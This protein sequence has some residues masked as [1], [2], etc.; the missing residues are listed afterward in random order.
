M[1]E[2]CSAKWAWLL[3]FFQSVIDV[4]PK[5]E[6]GHFYLGKYYDR[7]MG[8][9]AKDRP[10]KWANWTYSF[11]L[12]IAFPG[13]SD[14]LPFIIRHYGHTLEYG[15]KY[16][17]Q[18]MPRLLTLWLDFGCKVPDSGKA[19]ITVV[20]DVSHSVWSLGKKSQERSGAKTVQQLNDVRM[21]CLFSH[22]YF[23]HSI[24]LRLFKPCQSGYLHTST[25]LLSPSLYHEYVILTAMSFLCLKWALAFTS[26]WMT[27]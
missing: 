16:L 21:W 6:E 19:V 26:R 10:A 27:I 17:Y 23:P 14:F 9:M 13:N 12:Y 1:L 25:W 8:F 3:W 15:C 2:S 22:S 24:F 11:L 18:C 4:Q 20:Y 7:L 5:S